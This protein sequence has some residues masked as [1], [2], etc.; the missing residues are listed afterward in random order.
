[1]HRRTKMQRSYRKLIAAGVVLASLGL[2]A[3]SPVSDEV[4]L[5]EPSHVE[6]VEGSEFSHITLEARAAERIDLQTTEIA[7]QTMTSGPSKGKQRMV[8]PDGA[9][10]YGTDGDVYA[11][12]T[13]GELEYVRTPLVIDYIDGDTVFLKSGPPVGTEVVTVGVAELWGAES[14]VGH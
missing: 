10:H 14:G 4:T 13:V 12:T 6:A 11:Y 9:L 2:G 3:C 7:E 5:H 8:I 1:M